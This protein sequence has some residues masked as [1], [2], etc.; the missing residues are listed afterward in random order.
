MIETTI[1][2]FDLMQIARSGQCFRM[3]PI[4]V[5]RFAVIAG[6]MR[7]V[8]SQSGRMFRFECGRDEYE[9]VWRR[10][11]DLDADY[12][13]YIDSVAAD[14][15]FMREAVAFGSG[16]RVLR[17]DPWEAAVSFVL[18]QN[19]NI[20][21]IKVLI[22][23]LCARY[24]RR[25]V[26]ADG[27]AYHGFPTRDALR[28]ARVDDV[29]A[30]GAGYRD[31]YIVALARCDI[32]FAKL[33]ALPRED[34]YRQLTAVPGIGDKVANCILLYGLHHTDA[35]P[36]D[37]WIRRVIVRH[38]GQGFPFERYRGYAGIMQQYLFYYGRCGSA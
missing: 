20:P 26:S 14:D 13:A 24:G 17:Q 30:L 25:C 1:D 6:E 18:S 23:R 11:F 8:V 33:A 5:G 22:E 2:H 29:R 34:A 7:V 38:Y 35:F 16:M 10:Y 12:A 32:D 28:A 3:N 9:R 15:A 4:G 27:T 19:N 31:R 37:T 36:V 21:R